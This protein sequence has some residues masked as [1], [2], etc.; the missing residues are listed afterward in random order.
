M[1][2][3]LLAVALASGAMDITDRFGRWGVARTDT[4][5]YAFTLADNGASF[6]RYCTSGTDCAWT[7]M[8]SGSCEKDSITPVLASSTAS[9]VAMGAHCEDR[10]NGGMARYTFAADAK[11]DALLAG[12]SR[13]GFAFPLNN[14]TFRV[15]SFSLDGMQP[16]VARVSQNAGR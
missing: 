8:L 11:I 3:A 5:H 10:S 6:G 2:S 7:V 13:V 12:A 16:A 14:D 9:A 1:V 4:G 15:V